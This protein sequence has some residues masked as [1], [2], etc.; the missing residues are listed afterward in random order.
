MIN[1]YKLLKISTIFPNRWH[2]KKQLEKN[3]EK[4]MFY[5]D[6]KV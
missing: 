2:M 1:Y 4:V 6:E 5:C 3:N